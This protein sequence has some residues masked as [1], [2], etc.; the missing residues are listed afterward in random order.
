MKRAVFALAALIFVVAGCALKPKPAWIDAPLTA[1]VFEASAFVA[2]GIQ[3]TTQRCEGRSRLAAES[4]LRT[5]LAGSIE[6]IMG[7][8]VAENG[9]GDDETARWLVQGVSDETVERLLSRAQKIDAQQRGDRY[10]LL[11]GVPKKE[12]TALVKEAIIRGIRE[13]DLLYE[14]AVMIRA[15][16]DMDRFL[17]RY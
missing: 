8:F 12:A 16:D 14:Q 2:C 1:G 4:A 6:R 17:E 11:L 9:L 5:K 7:E 13:D 15:F 10:H 3:E